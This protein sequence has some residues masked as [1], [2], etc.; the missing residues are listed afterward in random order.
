MTPETTQI[1]LALTQQDLKHI[2]QIREQTGVD[3]TNAIRKALAT[4]AFITDAVNN[5]QKILI[6]NT[7]NHQL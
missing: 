5:G 7:I 3:E 2:N 1:Q 6:E 4:E